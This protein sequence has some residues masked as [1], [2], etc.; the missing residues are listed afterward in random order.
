MN[1][2]KI[3]LWTTG[4]LVGGAALGAGAVY[5][6]LQSLM[7]AKEERLAYRNEQV[8]ASIDKQ[9]EG[10]DLE[11]LR[12]KIPLMEQK[13]LGELQELLRQ[14]TIRHQDLVA[15]Y[16]LN[17]KEKDQSE[18]G[19]NAVS[20]INPRAMEEART[21]DEKPDE[22]LLAGI[23]VL[24]KENINTNNLPTSAGAYALK[25]FIPT[26]N[27]P[28]VDQL[29]ENGTI[30]LGKTNLSEMS[31]YMSQKNPSGYSAKKGQTTNPFNPL[32]LSPLGSSSGSA[33]AMA[34]DL[35]AVSLGTETSGSIVA[36]AA[37]NS[38]VGYKPTRGAISGEGVI[39][40]TYTLDTVGPITKTVEDALQTYRAATGKTSSLSLDKDFI[41]GKRIGLLKADKGFDKRLE[42]TLKNLGAQVVSL[43]IDTSK[44]DLDFILKNDLEKD[45]NHYLETSG[46]PISS[47]QELVDF[48]KQ[49]PEVR[50]R[51]GQNFL[52]EA[53]R[54][55]RDAAKVERILQIATDSLNQAID[56]QK[57]DVLVAKDNYYAHLAAGA[58]APE[59]TVPFGL[60]E[61]TPVGATFLAKAGQ[62][63]KVIQ[64]AYSFEQ[65]TQLRALPGE[66]ES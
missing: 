4:I 13:S 6:Y 51:Y 56:D 17:I 62:D 61:G 46:A 12:A 25:D 33:V 19:T 60:Q 5:L 16:L 65:L 37:I 66:Q 9:L 23:P 10:V 42:Q 29:L 55:K 39:P 40:I 8:L 52:E 2:K 30:I 21:F 27:A 35:A 58:G 15:Y 11:G 31:Y 14:G 26:K 32:V 47:L 63:E 18:L 59:L 34:T 44:I 43:D 45:L 54:P 57:L 38:V 22:R 64:I 20:E 1:V 48:N 41:K 49:D 3:A 24:V 7:P 50:M 28:V 53:L 36:P